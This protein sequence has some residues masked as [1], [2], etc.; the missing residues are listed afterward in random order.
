MGQKK[1]E[2]F[3]VLDFQSIRKSLDELNHY[4]TLRTHI[5]GYSLSVADL[6][7]WATI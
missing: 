6:A 4:F 1:S 5:V 7:V 2:D 3:A